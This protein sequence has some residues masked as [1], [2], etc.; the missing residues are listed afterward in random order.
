MRAPLQRLVCA[1]AGAAT[2]M[3]MGCS[4][5]KTPAPT[6]PAPM[7]MQGWGNATP[8][9]G[10]GMLT[11]ALTVAPES[12]EVLVATA[13]AE[14]Y[15]PAHLTVSGKL[16]GR[17]GLRYKGSDGTLAVCFENGRQICDKASFKIR[18]D[19]YDAGGSFANATRLNFNSMLGDPSMLRERL[20][21]EVFRRMQ[22]ETPRVSN[23]FL[24]I[25]G[26]RKGVF[27]V[28]EN[29]DIDF[30]QS[31]WPTASQGNLYKEV[32]PSEVM[33]ENYTEALETNKAAADNTQMAMFAQA[34]FAAKGPALAAVVDRFAHVDQLMRYM[35][36]DRALN[37]VDGTTTF[38][39]NQAGQECSN[40]NFF[41]YQHPTD[42]RFVL[43]P[44]DLSF[45]F[46]V[47][48]GFDKIPGWDQPQ[49][50]CGRR[51]LVDMTPVLHPACD[52][53]F[54]GLIAAGR[55][56]YE[57]G[58]DRLLQVWD[59]GQLVDLIE[60]WAAEIEPGVALD[61]NGPGT[62]AWH[63][64]VDNLKAYVTVLRER[65]EAIRAARTVPPFGL[66][67]PGSNDFEG[68]SPLAFQLGASGETSPRSGS[69]L[70]LNITKPLDGA[71]DV[72]F[73]FDFAND[74]L[75]AT[76][77]LKAPWVSARLPLAGGP[78]DL[79]G[80]KEIHLKVAADDIRR[81]RIELDSAKYPNAEESGRF[82]QDFLI[83]RGASELVVRVADLAYPAGIENDPA[84]VAAVV[85]SC[86]GLV[87]TPTPRGLDDK[88]LL[89]KGR[90]DHG[91]LRI[92][93]V[94]FDE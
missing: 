42:N 14:Q 28:V 59:V 67:A 87:F 2:A 24:T 26:E 52:P 72:Y 15:V 84:T 46:W 43:V 53:L 86:T 22:I 11:Y 50:D 48:T 36:V 9:G 30:V 71:Q 33:A 8:L 34:L 27:A 49:A 54:Q 89:P 93:N 47:Q 3:A 23:A 13:V 80:V 62:A 37:N 44:W 16:V 60:R 45:T 81:V 19:K 18:F 39:C 94:S 76:P 6:T 88:G 70:N 61:P 40:H 57:Q 66:V 21:S 31:R 51:H 78:Q 5:D 74:E 91:F 90:A 73:G 58:L 38:Y 68:I 69:T 12:L 75:A 4:G 83:G 79:S 32:W 55:P 65:L 7:L 10:G 63:A 17:V 92:D 1:V 20:A 35:A 82:G 25:N 77:E 41:W 64:A 29:P 85:A 56:A